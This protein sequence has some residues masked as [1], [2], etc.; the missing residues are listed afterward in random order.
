MKRN[1]FKLIYEHLKNDIQQGFYQKND[2]LPSEH[3]LVE[4]F[5][6]SRE[7]IRKALKLLS[8]H[9]YIQKIQG[10]GSL[11]LNNPKIQFPV[12][13]LV[14]FKELA[15]SIGNKSKTEVISLHDKPI[16]EPLLDGVFNQNDRVWEIIRVRQID[17]ENIILDKDFLLKSHVP[18]ITKEQCEH[19][20]YQYVENELGLAISF[21]KK[22]ITV[23]D[24]TE[25]DKNLL[26]LEGFS[27]IVV[28]RSLVY[29]EDASLF[30]YT[31]SRHRTD[32][33]RFVDFARRIK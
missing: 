25:E 16:I 9:G 31:E 33:F 30:Q 8:E 4:S 19:S 27:N 14:S 7:T 22:E 13:G 2:Y 11:V 1:K 5:Q 3:E 24:V 12:T 26:D 28:V 23:E 20:I 6:A 29:L 32:K 18:T 17:G 15:K 10:K 21:A